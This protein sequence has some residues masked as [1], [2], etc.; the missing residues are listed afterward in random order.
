LTRR[1]AFTAGI[2]LLGVALQFSVIHWTRIAGIEPDLLL[3]VTVIIGLLS[4]P[5]AGMATGFTAGV[6]E[7]AL[8]GRWMG[9]YA[10]AKTGIGF[11]SGIAGARLFVENL[12]VIMGVSAVMT[13]VHEGILGLFGPGG[14]GLWKTIG[15][16]LGQA[17]YNAGV[18]II[19]GA[20]LRAVRQWLPAEEPRA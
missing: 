1:A 8:V 4:G 13:L 9:V 16:G 5:R 20:A 14:M 10:G 18:A 17:A 15:L 19:V 2:I 12:L 3:V 6:L 11:L 7:G